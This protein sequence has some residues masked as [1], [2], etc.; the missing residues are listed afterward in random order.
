[1]MK[2]R[3]SIWSIIRSGNIFAIYLLVL[4]LLFSIVFLISSTNLKHSMYF[5]VLKNPGN[6]IPHHLLM[7][8]LAFEIPHFKSEFYIDDGEAT[9][10]YLSAAF[11]I[12]TEIKHNDLSS[13]LGKE[14]PG[15][16]FFNTEIAVAGLGTDLTTLPIESPPPIEALL[17]QEDVAEHGNENSGNESVEEASVF[18]YHSHSWESFKPLMGEGQN[19][20]ASTNPKHNVISVGSMLKEELNNKGI[21]V[22]HNTLNIT[23]ELNSRNWNYKHSY[24]LSREHV[25]EVM[26]NGKEIKYL[27]D[28]HRDSQ[29]KKITT[30]TIGGE[31]FARLFFIVG[32]ENKNYEANLHFA[33]KLHQEL[34]A[35]YPGISRGVFIKGKDDGNGVYNQDITDRAMLLEFGGIDNTMEELRNSTRAFAEVFSDFFW[36]AEE[37]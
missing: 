30:I 1:M 11:N 9:D 35:K 36:K 20:A 29:P 17:E 14:I 33:T 37:L 31:S 19:D 25:Q 15:F 16:S 18:I 27:I 23:Q 7:D 32:K 6:T 28:I 10:T 3:N 24:I 5:S 21:G 2:N 8:L 13:L 26:T 12:L 34:E 4:A 22:Q